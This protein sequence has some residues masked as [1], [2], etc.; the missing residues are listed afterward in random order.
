MREPEIVVR[1]K[2]SDGELFEGQSDARKHE[3]KI[4]NR[5]LANEMLAEGCP[6][7]SILRKLGHACIDPVLN[8]VTKDS[9]M[10]I[11]HWQCSDSAAYRIQQFGIGMNVYLHGNCSTWSAGF[12]DWIS[13]ETLVR[14]AENKKSKL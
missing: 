3:K 5:D 9:M 11:Q 12:G 6:V 2:T 7:G 8:K 1:Y 4:I 13:L 10:C 14:Y